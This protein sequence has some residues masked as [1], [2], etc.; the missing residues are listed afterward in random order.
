MRLPT[1]HNGYLHVDM[2]TININMEAGYHINIC[3]V[4]LVT[5]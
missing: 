4:I 2:L 3:I 5:M 1:R